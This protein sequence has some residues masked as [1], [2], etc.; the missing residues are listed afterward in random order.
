M[1]A[2]QHIIT[3]SEATRCIYAD[4][5]ADNSDRRTP[6]TRLDRQLLLV[7]VI[8]HAINS[9]FLNLVLLIFIFYHS[10]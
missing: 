10:L 1:L 2:I 6:Q 9:Y 8:D 5:G 3:L 7:M 4:H